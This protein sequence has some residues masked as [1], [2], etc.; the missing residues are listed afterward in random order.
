MRDLRASER[1]AYYS[2]TPPR[3]QR[4]AT[5]RAGAPTAIASRHLPR[6][7]RMLRR[8]LHHLRAALT[9]P[10]H[11]VG[12]AGPLQLF[13]TARRL[14]RVARLGHRRVE[15]DLLGRRLHAPDAAAVL[16]LFEEIWLERD[17]FTE[18]PADRPPR[19]LD[20][21]ANIG[22]AS[23]YLLALRPES[24]IE[25][26]EPNPTA[27][28]ALRRTLAAND[29]EGRVRLHEVALGAEEGRATLAADAQ[30]GASLVASTTEGRGVGSA[31]VEV[32]VARLSR[33]VEEEVDLL[34][35]DVEGA[36][37]EVLRELA[38]A[39]RLASIRAVVCEAHVDP[40]HRPR[41]REEVEG[42]LRDAGFTVELRSVRPAGADANLP[43]DVLLHA[44][45]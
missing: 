39:D 10:R 17:Y 41:R 36:E 14:A 43:R 5:P 38:E 24:R 11:E 31:S 40:V 25:A 32:E 18:L 30:R 4:A 26:F 22:M 35:L 23:L 21:G 6:T 27:A 19:I 16:F 28:A 1:P 42:L 2:D 44:I 45:R 8:S 34:K 15:V 3:S 29:L 9:L 7:P 13:A 33:W 37:L 12:G 20:A